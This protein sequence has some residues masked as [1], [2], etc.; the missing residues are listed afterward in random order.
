MMIRVNGEEKIFTQHVTTIS[1]LLAALGAQARR[2]AVEI[3][4][5]ITDPALF[6]TTPVHDRDHVEIV[7]FVGGG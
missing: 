1:E 5:S 4:G 6:E 7:S 2:V 3:N